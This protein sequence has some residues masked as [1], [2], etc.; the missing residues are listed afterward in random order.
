MDTEVQVQQAQKPTVKQRAV[1]LF[2]DFVVTA[3][4]M[5]AVLVALVPHPA[6]ADSFSMDT[7]GMMS[8]AASIFNSLWPAFEIIVGI[9]LGFAILAYIVREIR[10]AI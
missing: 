1:R 3:V 7:T 2:R 10:Q 5:T 4:I 6:L 8:N 9:S